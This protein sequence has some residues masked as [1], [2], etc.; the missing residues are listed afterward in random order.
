MAK[1]V[2]LGIILAYESTTP[3]TFTTVGELYD[4]SPNEISAD[5]VDVTDHSNTDGIRRKIAALIDMGSFNATV[6]FDPALTVYS[7]LKTILDART[8]KNWRFTFPTGTA[9]TYPVNLTNLGRE[10]PIDGRMEIT[11]TGEVAGPQ[12]A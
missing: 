10:T 1:K 9:E 2:G 12:G 5:T 3:G 11:F 6:A 7:A 4:F 8:V